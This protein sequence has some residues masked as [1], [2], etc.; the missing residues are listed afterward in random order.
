MNLNELAEERK[1]TIKVCGENVIVDSSDEI[2]ST[3]R[4]IL[5]ERGIDSFSIVIDGS[6]VV[7]I[8]TIP[9]T[10]G[11]VTFVEVMRQAKAGV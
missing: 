7:N 4:T 6:E 1:V 3:L 5:E 8:N 10:F 11:D 2:V 9:S